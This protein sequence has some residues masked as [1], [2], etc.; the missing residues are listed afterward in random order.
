MRYTPAP[1]MLLLLAPL[2]CCAL[3]ADLHV[4][5]Q[6]SLWLFCAAVVILMLID[7]LRLGRPASITVQRQVRRSLPLNVWSPLGLTVTNT[8][9]Q[10]FAARCAD[11]WP[12]DIVLE[13]ADFSL[14]LRPGEKAE[15]SCRIR[16][17]QRG[18]YDLPGLD[19]LMQSPWGLW[20]RSW[21]A[22][23]PEQVRV[24]PNFREL[25][26]FTLLAAAA[27]LN[28]MG[29]KHIAKQG[30]GQEFQE[31]REYYPGDSLR[32]IDW[33]ATARRQQLISREYQDERD[34]H[35]VLVLDC[36]RRM[37]HLEASGS[38][39]DQALNSALLLA[40]VAAR[41]GD[42][43]GLLACAE[44]YTWY[45]PAQKANAARSLL[46][47]GT[48]L[49]AETVAMDYHQLTRELATR[50]KRRSLVI[51][52]TN[53]RAEEHDTLAVLVRQLRRRHLLVIADLLEED[54]KTAL[55]RPIHTPQEAWR[56]QALLAH[57]AERRR[58]ALTL[59]RL[60]C[61]ALNLT[62]RE[63]PAA[64][65]NTYLEIKHARRL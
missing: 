24:L 63:L 2:A 43:V 26:R 4:F 38:Q 27:Q 62:A 60:G 57:M 15:I 58:F 16:P 47:A 3:M 50:L 8:G 59:A 11:R 31:L 23:C 29:I 56:Y 41:Q 40:H 13:P 37:R 55:E 53:T 54:I 19:T 14:T 1:K 65:V 35:I 44:Q 52:L 34:Q 49:F 61:R 17:E 48:R 42:S 12:Q 64:L 22:V 28:L 45:P 25:H 9:R 51:L 30:D 21:L 46:L 5:G 33:K 18:K 10:P 36:G 32:Q 20:R 6:G 7:L 39:F